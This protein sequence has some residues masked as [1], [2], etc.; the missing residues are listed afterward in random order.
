M[1]KLEKEIDVEALFI[2]PDLEIEDI[3]Q[4]KDAIISSI[5]QRRK[6][7]KLVTS[8]SE[9]KPGKLSEDTAKARKGI[10]YWIINRN[11]DA[12]PLLESAHASRVVNYF[13]GLGYLEANKLDSAYQLIKKLYQENPDKLYFIA[14][15]VD[16]SIKKSEIEETLAILEKAKKSYRNES[17]LYY[18]A[19]V[20]LDYLGEYAKAKAE[21]QHALRLNP[22]HASSLFRQAYWADLRGQDEVAISTYEKLSSFKPPYVN[23]LIN[24]GILYEDKG[25]YEKAVKCYQRVL[26]YYPLHQRTKMYLKDALSSK[27]MYYD[28]E[29]K[30]REHYWQ[31]VMTIPISDFPMSTRSKATLDELNIKTLG[32]LASQGE[33]ELL[34]RENFGM[35][36]LNELKEILARK[37]LTFAQTGIPVTNTPRLPPLEDSSKKQDILNKSL[38]DMDWST[39]IRSCFGKLKIYTLRD[40]VNKSEGELLGARNLG[41]ISLREIKQ[42][43][44]ELGLSLRQQ[45]Q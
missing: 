1:T 11:N 4:I 14:P 10:A 32:D 3:L 39:R 19:G 12:I 25:E 7:E 26:E 24:L 38:F 33:E 44:A 27:D 43:L 45:A 28:E 36:S 37:G 9:D 30:R 18:Y 13:L 2:Q 20:C 31:N 8:F 35:T 6:F 29:L 22:G 41:Q 34:N 5:V 40:L 15:F 17:D 16:V 23:A 21:Y 42:R